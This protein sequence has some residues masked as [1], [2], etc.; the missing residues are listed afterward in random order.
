MI[1]KCATSDWVFWHLETVKCQSRFSILRGG[2]CFILVVFKVFLIFVRDFPCS[3]VVGND[4]MASICYWC[5][6]LQAEC[7]GIL[8]FSKMKLPFLS[9]I[10]RYFFFF[11]FLSWFLSNTGKLSFAEVLS[12]SQQNEL[13]F[14]LKTV[15]GIFKITLCL[16]DYPVFMWQSLEVFKALNTS[17]LKQFFLKRR[18]FFKKTKVTFL[19]E[20]TTIE[21]ESALTMFSIIEWGVL[22]GPMTKNGFFWKFSLNMRTSYR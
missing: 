4:F 22:N 10:L 9:L 14:L 21:N 11:F 6:S 15:L 12:R 16:R 7:F 20:N 18:T 1:L 17:T 8:T 13:R 5:V 19:V 3:S 2:F